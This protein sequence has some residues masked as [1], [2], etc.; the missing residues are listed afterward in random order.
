MYSTHNEVKYIF[1]ERFIRT[2]K[3]K[4]TNRWLQFK[5]NVHIDKF[6]NIVKKYNSSYHRIIK[7]KPVDVKWKHV[8]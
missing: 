4:F 6:G 7:M 8:Y 2:L 3:T 5:K 1:A